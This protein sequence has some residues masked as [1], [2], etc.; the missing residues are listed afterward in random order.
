MIQPPF[1]SSC[2]ALQYEPG[3][4]FSSYMLLEHSVK[5][6]AMMPVLHDIISLDVYMS[7]KATCL[8]I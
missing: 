3:T 7:S 5:S 8:E 2:I 6:M 4:K 1:H